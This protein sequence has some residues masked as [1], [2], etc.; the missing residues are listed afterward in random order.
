ME[1]IKDKRILIIVESPNKKSTILKILKTAGYKNVS[2]M[3]SVGHIQELADDRSSWKNTGIWPDKNF[4]MNLKISDSKYKTASD[5]KLAAQSAEIIMLATDPDREGHVISDSLLKQLDLPK[6]KCYRMVMHEITPKA[7]VSA[8]ENPIPFQLNSVAAG[9][10]RACV[11]KLLGYGLSPWAKTYVG[12]KSV[13]RCQSA[14]L[15][16]ITEREKEIRDFKPTTFYDLYLNFMKNDVK[17]KAKYVGT[18][19]KPVEHLNSREEVNAVI[20]KCN[21]SYKILDIQKKEKLENPKAPFDTPSFQQEAA[22]KLGLSV[23]D[24]QSCAQKLFEGVE[25]NGDHLGLV[26][27]IR[28]DST[29]MSKEFIPEL[30]AYINSTYGPNSFHQPK[31]GKKVENAQEGHEALRVTDPRITPDIAKQYLKSDFLVKVYKLIWQRTIASALPPAKISETTYLIENNGQ[32]FSLVS[33]EIVDLGYRTIYNYKDESSEDSVLIT[34]TFKKNE[35]L[36]D[37]ELD[38]V[39]KATKPK[40]RFKQAT[41]INELKKKGIGRPSTYQSILETILSPVRGYCNEVNKELV[42]TELGMQLSAALTRAYP[43]LININYT[44]DLESQLDLI[45]KGDLEPLDFLRGFFTNLTESIDKNSE[46]KVQSTDKKCPNC[47][48]SLVVRRNRW[49]KLFLGCSNYPKCTF[50]E[51]IK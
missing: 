45:E 24:A 43:D 23:K 18:A 46:G 4:K 40:P 31:V 50:I 32:L 3:A 29:E 11:D 36:S 15:L 8:I 38:A 47:G 12:A 39:E 2:V 6:N 41:F 37:C 20:D 26:T 49:G 48:N 21:S 34:E 28:T 27:Y 14:A 9:L 5:I 1:N 44:K 17:F 22:S 7:V 42:P 35:K 30:K 33:N 10:A 19:D 25:V 51:N 16:L 13:G